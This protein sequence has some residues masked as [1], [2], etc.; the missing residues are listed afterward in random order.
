M[1]AWLLI[2]PPTILLLYFLLS[3]ALRQVAASSG[4][5]SNTAEVA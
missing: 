2:G 1:S 3:R 5:R 4:L